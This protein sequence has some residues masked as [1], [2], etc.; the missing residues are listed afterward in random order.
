[1]SRISCE[2]AIARSPARALAICACGS[3][4][5]AQAGA[6]RG[7]AAQRAHG[8]H[9][10]GT[11][12]QRGPPSAALWRAPASQGAAR[13]QLLKVGTGEGVAARKGSSRVAC[14]P[15]CLMLPEAGTLGAWLTLHEQHKFPEDKHTCSTCFVDRFLKRARL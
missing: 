15:G 8:S 5:F 2:S 11:M 4:A 3:A 6:R 13:G 7:M 12:V 14:G 9:C 1:M 10:S